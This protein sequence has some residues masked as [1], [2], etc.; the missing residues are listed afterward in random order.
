[1]ISVVFEYLRKILRKRALKANIPVIS[2][3]NIALGGSG[4]TPLVYYLAQSLSQFYEKVAILTRGYGKLT[5]FSIGYTLGATDDEDFRYRIKGNIIRVANKDRATALSKLNDV[6]LAILDDGFQYQGLL[7]D[8]E[9][10]VVNPFHRVSSTY[11]FPLG[12]LREPLQSLRFCDII[13]LNYSNFV[14]S[15]QVN[16]LLKVLL[17]FSK[18]IYKMYYKIS[19]FVHCK[20]FKKIKNSSLVNQ[21]CDVFCGIGFYRGFTMLLKRYNI[22][23]GKVYK[24]NDHH[25][26]S[27]CELEAILSQRKIVITTEK[28]FLRLNKQI[29]EKFDNLYYPVI[30]V[31]IHP[32]F[33]EKVIDILKNRCKIN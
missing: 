9:I 14:N 28:D 21:R 8:L 27:S 6:S 16:L 22:G 26:Y 1:M 33:V 4:K 18:P 5:K 3:G 23:C 31:E 20:T 11:L 13:V 25:N 19:Y 2:V 30:D 12:I 32:L 29:I 17:K 24:F 15:D 10:V 7:K